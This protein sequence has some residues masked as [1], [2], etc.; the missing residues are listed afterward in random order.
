MTSTSCLQLVDVAPRVATYLSEHELRILKS[1]E[2]LKF[3]TSSEDVQVYDVQ[4][5]YIIRALIIVL[6]NLG[7]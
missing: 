5:W 7:A 1:S 4:L 3:G 6:E 2:P